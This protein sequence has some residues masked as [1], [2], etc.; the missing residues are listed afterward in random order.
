VRWPSGLSEQ[1]DNLAVDSIH[2]I[3]EGS[4]RPIEKQKR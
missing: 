2:A 4:G 3:K 1:F